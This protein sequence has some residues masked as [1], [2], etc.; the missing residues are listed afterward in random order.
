MIAQ[1][2]P[3]EVSEAEDVEGVAGEL[4][5]TTKKK[6]EAARE[7][8]EGAGEDLILLAG[9]EVEEEAGEGAQSR[10]FLALAGDVVAGTGVVG[11]AEVVATVVIKEPA[12]TMITTMVLALLATDMALMTTVIERLFGSPR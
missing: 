9:V 1:K 12:T 6:A 4:S 11:E 3:E 10:D 5:K 7:D 2:N 8:V